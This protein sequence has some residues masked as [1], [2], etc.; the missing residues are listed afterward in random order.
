MQLGK[1]FNMDESSKLNYISHNQMTI[2]AM[3]SALFEIFKVQ[4]RHFDY[5]E[6]NTVKCLSILNSILFTILKCVVSLQEQL[7][8]IVE[9][10]YLLQ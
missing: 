5:V 1:A 4:I 10:V 6:I 3:V 2:T 9:K 7:K 8:L